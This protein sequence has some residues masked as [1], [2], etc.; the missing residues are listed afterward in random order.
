MMIQTF[1]PLVRWYAEKNR[2]PTNVLPNILAGRRL[3][4]AGGSQ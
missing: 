1:V 3:E 2:V 4:Y